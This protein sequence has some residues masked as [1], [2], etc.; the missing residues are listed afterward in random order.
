MP[1]RLRIQ[2]PVAAGSHDPAG[3][4][5]RDFARLCA[6][7]Q[8]PGAT[9]GR[10]GTY[11]KR[12]RHEYQENR[13]LGL[14][15]WLCVVWNFLG[16]FRRLHKG[17]G[18]EHRVAVPKSS[19]ITGALPKEIPDAQPPRLRRRYT[20]GSR[21]GAATA[22]PSNGIDSTNPRSHSRVRPR[23]GPETVPG[24]HRRSSRVLG[25]RC[26]SLIHARNS[27]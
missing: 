14:A 6:R 23:A 25:R 12:Q 21:S 26:D 11:P 16:L 13:A 22:Y 5:R 8:R 20:R 4:N 7:V 9:S 15:D 19:T 2:Q 17:A 10:P 1:G 3:V 27:S 24:A 18:G